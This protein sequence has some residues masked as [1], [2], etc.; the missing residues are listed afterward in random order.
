LRKSLV[1]GSTNED[2][3][4]SG[5]TIG[6]LDGDGDPDLLY[7]NG[8]AFDYSRPGPRAWHGVQWL[9]NQAG[10]FSFHRIG[11]LPGAY[12]PVCADL[13]GDGDQ[14]Y[15]AVSGF[16]NWDD[17]HAVSMRAW[18]N[19]GRQHFRP[20]TLAH[21]PTHLLTLD[22]ADMDGDGVP[23]LITGGFHAYPPWEHMSRVLLWKRR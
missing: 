2:Y 16:N 22:A 13:D 9:E 5:L 4:S 11:E 12:S 17:P 20:V 19:D 18:L 15:V 8:D 6:D 7:A 14:D 23:E 1:W 3:G 21:Q 10:V